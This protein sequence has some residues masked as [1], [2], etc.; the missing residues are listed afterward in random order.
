M[1]K[2]LCNLASRIT[3]PLRH[4]KEVGWT[5]KITLIITIMDGKLNLTQPDVEVEEALERRRGLE[6]EGKLDPDHGAVIGYVLPLQVP[7]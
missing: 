1:G 3:S 7:F 2:D 5:S 4:D 6:Q